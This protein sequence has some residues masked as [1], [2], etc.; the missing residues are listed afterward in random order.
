MHLFLKSISYIFHPVFI[1][2][3]GV[4]FYYGVN[5]TY[6]PKEIILQRLSGAFILSV[7]IP[8]LFF[9]LLK[10]I[11][12]ASSFMLEN[13]NE[14]RVPLI[15]TMILTYIIA[16]RVFPDREHNVLYH[17]FIGILISS[18]LCYIL[19]M[20]GF[21]ASVHMMAISG[22]TLFFVGL[23]IHFKTNIYL[24]ITLLIFLNGAVAS[25]RLHL[26]AHYPLELVIGAF[27]G[28][29]PQFV[30]MFYWMQLL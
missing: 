8:L 7:L 19:S 13:V 9:L 4:C 24:V 14:R 15:A 17:F 11:G 18:A 10:T 12:K 29:I 23:S 3:I 28:V 30:L 16:A 1:P 5:P 21:K 20:I 25:S 2:F 26:K 27:V 22:L 6:I